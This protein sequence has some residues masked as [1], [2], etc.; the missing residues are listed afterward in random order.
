MSVTKFPRR[1]VF[2]REIN[3]RQI[4]RV[5]APSDEM[6]WAVCPWVKA[7]IGNCHHCPASEILDGEH[8]DEPVTRGCRVIAEEACR[9][10]F[11]ALIKDGLSRRS[12]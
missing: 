12:P 10:V 3:G 11:A 8:Y 5:P 2:P 6:I 4:W 7:K 9:V 1:R